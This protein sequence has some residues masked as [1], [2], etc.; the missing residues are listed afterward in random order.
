MN[1][2]DTKKK[3]K[4]QIDHDIEQLDTAS[5]DY[6]E[7][8]S[9]EIQKLGTQLKQ[10]EEL[11]TES[12]KKSEKRHKV[13]STTADIGMKAVGLGTYV[14]LAI[15]GYNYEKNGTF[16]SPTFKSHLQKLNPFK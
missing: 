16:C 6:R 2:E 3:L 11:K 4:E 1:I 7:I 15:C 10:L 5:N 12:E 8:L 14:V 13:L 9:D